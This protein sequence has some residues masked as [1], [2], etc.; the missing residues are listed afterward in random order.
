MKDIP[1]FITPRKQPFLHSLLP[2]LPLARERRMD[3]GIDANSRHGELLAELDRLFSW[4]LEETNADREALEETNRAV[5][6][7]ED[8]PSG[9]PEAPRWQTDALAPAT[10]EDGEP[11]E[12][13]AGE[14]KPSDSGFNAPPSGAGRMEALGVLAGGIA[15]D[16][17][18]ILSV[19]LGCTA[20]AIEGLPADSLPRSNME[21]V[22][23]AAHRAKELTGQMLEFS[24]EIKPER[25]P[26]RAQMPS[27]PSGPPPARSRSDWRTLKS[28]ADGRKIWHP[29]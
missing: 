8:G 27:R 2:H 6:K 17:N 15:H 21:E 1:R 9:W 25:K 14:T 5:T 7:S 3:S 22:L 12:R 26:V 24:R 28:M 23:I 11:P 20:L 13:P 10:I 19:I 29:A 18:N 16:F 4:N